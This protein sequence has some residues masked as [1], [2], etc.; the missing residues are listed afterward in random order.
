MP[1]P[2]LRL[3]SE[4]RGSILVVALGL[5]VL[6]TMA[7]SGFIAIVARAGGSGADELRYSRIFYAAESGLNMGVRWCKH[8]PKE[9]FN[10][11]SESWADG[12]ILTQDSD[13]PGTAGW[14]DFDGVK[15]K[16]VFLHGAPGGGYHEIRSFATSGP[17]QDTVKLSFQITGAGIEAGM[18]PLTSFGG[19]YLNTW[20]ED[21]IPGR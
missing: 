13:V 21:L 8:Y 3:G 12:L 15:V 7:V 11:G 20:T 2:G 6:L 19:G 4:E 10:E 16:V 5:S 17:G 14:S 18:N 1:Q 9:K